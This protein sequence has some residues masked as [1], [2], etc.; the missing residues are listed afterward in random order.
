MRA[1]GTRAKGVE[2]PHGPSGPSSEVERLGAALI[3]RQFLGC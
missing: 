3:G 2:R 1:P